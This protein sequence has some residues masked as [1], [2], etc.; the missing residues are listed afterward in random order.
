MDPLVI[1]HVPA[2]VVQ[3]L[4]TRVLR[5]DWP[6]GEWLVLPIDARAGTVHVAAERGAEVVGVGTV[7]AAAPDD[8]QIGI[9]PDRAFAPGAG[10][11]LRGMATSAEARGQGVGAAVLAGCVEAVRAGGGTVLWCCA[12]RAAVRFYERGGLAAVGD[13]FDIAGIGPH[14]VM[15][16]P[17]QGVHDVGG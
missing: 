7:Y 10:W 14:V 6:A 16:R 13:E 11:H 17:V 8:D 3:P 4:R 2:A 1:R 5:P 12:R 15:W 9:L